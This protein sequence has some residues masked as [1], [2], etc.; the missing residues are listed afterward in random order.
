MKKKK[1]T[2]QVPCTVQELENLLH[3]VS[4]EGHWHDAKVSI[5]KDN[6]VISYKDDLKDDNE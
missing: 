2:I 1:I 4:H 6:I 3:I 5:Q